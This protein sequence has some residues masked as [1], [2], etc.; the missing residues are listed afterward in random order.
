MMPP[1]QVSAVCLFCQASLMQGQ[2]AFRDCMLQ[3][4]RENRHLRRFTSCARSIDHAI[5]L[6]FA[7]HT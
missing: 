7:W 6:S 4:V 3:E 1:L 5:L 2:E